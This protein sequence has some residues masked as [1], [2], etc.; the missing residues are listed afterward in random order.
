MPDFPNQVNTIQAP[1]VAGDFASANPRASVLAGEGALISGLG[2][3]NGVTVQGAV[4]GRFGW[5]TYQQIDNDNAP[6]VLN[7]FGAGIP[8]G[9][10]ARRQVGLITQYLGTSVQ[11]LQTGFQIMAFNN[12]DMWVVNNGSQAAQV[13]MKAFANFADGSA[14]FFAAGTISTS[15][16][17]LPG[18]SGSA[19]SIAA[20]TFSATGTINGD[21][22]TATGSVTGANGIVAGGTLSGTGVA[23]GTKIVNQITPLLAGEA[24]GGI[25]RY[26]VSIPEQTVASTTISGTYGILTV[27]GTVVA[28][29][30]SG[31]TISGAGVTAGTTIYTQLT[32]TPGAAGTYVVD[33]TQVVAGPIAITAAST[34]ETK[35]MA[36]SAGAIGELIK[37]SPTI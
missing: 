36:K 14:S 16:P 24:L 6:A 15:T 7:T 20:G 5:L 2:V 4:V 26:N 19:S 8:A 31:Q 23:T 10:V 3:I 1:A 29:F 33:P 34:V 12:V 30:G 22:F 21:V 27:G 32:G 9:L 28:G 11:Y 13:G 35:W 17:P 25:G 18:G 37:I